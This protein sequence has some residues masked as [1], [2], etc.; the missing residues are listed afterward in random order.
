MF[1]FTFQIIDLRLR[2]IGESEIEIDEIKKAVSSIVGVASVSA[3]KGMGKLTV[4]GYVDPVE[5]ATCLMEFD[6]MMVEIVSV[7]VVFNEKKESNLIS[8]K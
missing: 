5:V 2:F 8:Y 1:L 6:H 3:H 4:T 7:K